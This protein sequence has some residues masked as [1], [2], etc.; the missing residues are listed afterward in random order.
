MNTLQ[1]KDVIEKKKYVDK[2]SAKNNPEGTPRKRANS[3]DK[4]TIF[5]SGS[6][7]VN[8]TDKRTIFHSGSPRVNSIDKRNGIH[9]LEGSPRID[10]RSAKNNI[11]GTPRK[12]NF[13]TST[14]NS[15]AGFYY[16]IKLFVIL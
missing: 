12:R 8:S 14:I 4:R 16:Y 13:I 7:R 9:N 2:R 1:T 10:T 6:P 11:E 15:S 5:H 3:I